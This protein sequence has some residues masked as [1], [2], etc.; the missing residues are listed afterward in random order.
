[1][2]KNLFAAL[3][4]IFAA[5]LAQAKPFEVFRLEIP[6]AVGEQAVAVRPSGQRFELGRVM[7]VP[8]TTKYP[9]F[10]AS[11][12]AEPGTVAATAVNAIHITVSVE[13][14]KGRIV[15]L[16]PRST[17]APAAGASSA[18]ILDCTAGT[19]LFGG[20][21]PLAGSKA[22][23][24]RADGSFRILSKD[25]LP[26][27]G[28]TLVIWVTEDPDGPYMIDIENKLGGKVTAY[29]SP[30]G[31]RVVG[32]V[33]RAFYG[34]GRFYGSKFQ[35]RSALRANHPGVICVSTCELGDIGGFQ[36]IPYEHSFSKEMVKSAWEKTQ[37]LI[38]RSLDGET[39]NG[40]SPLFSGFLTPGAQVREKLWN[41]WST[42]GRRS[43][44][45]CR[46]NGREWQRFPAAVGRDDHIYDDI[47]HVR[48]YVP[49]T[50]EPFGETDIGEYP[51]K[52]RNER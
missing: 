16:L 34:T 11:A 13:N 37:W 51:I 18:F 3:L 24:R 39:M 33:E 8:E 50:K 29:Y 41:F 6:A 5:S 2:M 12:W 17:I 21:S 46:V 15:S 40:R 20:W 31:S 9:G 23:V 26:Q 49:Y 10:T 27:Q 35:R 7:R 28:E 4:L 30:C 38:I 1:M 14:E 47:T 36:I 22:R 48:L 42:F 45:M 52:K 44:V 25:A 43:L 19:K 32:T